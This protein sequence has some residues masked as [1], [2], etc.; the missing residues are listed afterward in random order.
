MNRAGLIAQANQMLNNNILNPQQLRWMDKPAGDPSGLA[1][2]KPLDSL[3]VKQTLSLT[4]MMVG[5]PG[6][7]KYGI[8]NNKNEQVYYA[9]EESDFC[10]RA[11]C[12]QTRRFDL[13][14]VDSANQELIR[15]RREF[16]CC[17]GCCWFACC[18]GCSQE[19]MVE[20]PP[21]TVIGSVT[22]ECSCWRIHYTLKDERD[23]PVLKIVGP[24]CMCDGPYAC[25]CENKFTIYGTD[26]ATEVGAIYKKY[27][28]FIAESMTSS[29]TFTLQ[30]PMDLSVRMKAVALGALFLIDFSHF[31]ENRRR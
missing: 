23:N 21:G 9:F 12:P 18:G 11:Y 31:V 20:S 30:M 3:L 27:A 25:C 17:S 6:S 10:Q 24:G 22:Q 26:G 5:I 13:H 8:F 2:L 15:L 28:G 4:E 19:I 29:D 16:K 14:V 1:Y 7:A